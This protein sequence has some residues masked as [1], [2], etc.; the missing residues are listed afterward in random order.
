MRPKG[1]GLPALEALG[2]VR[3]HVQSRRRSDPAHQVR[4][5]RA[6]PQQP[7]DWFETEQVGHVTV[8]RFTPRCSRFLKDQTI[9][10]LADRLFGLLPGGSR[11][12]LVLNFTH[13]RRLDSLLLGKL[14]G[15]HKKALAG[16]GRVVLC[17]LTP[18]LYEVFQT[19]QLTGFL[20]IYGTEQEALQ[21]A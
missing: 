1:S 10:E 5:E 14:V 16:G 3:R 2:G 11:R 6:T 19:L 15:L 4:D 7:D 21:H 20:R 9:K 8:V 13:V 17:H 18:Q 12:S